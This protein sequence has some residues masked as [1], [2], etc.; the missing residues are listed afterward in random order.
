M[1]GHI[2]VSRTVRSQDLEREQ[3]FCYMFQ[4]DAEVLGVYFSALMLWMVVATIESR[5]SWR[6][7]YQFLQYTSSHRGL[8]P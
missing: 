4:P 5:G 3:G 1:E 2:P 8:K 6:L 7:L